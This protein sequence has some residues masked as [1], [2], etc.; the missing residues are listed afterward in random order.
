MSRLQIEPDRPYGV[1]LARLIA[2]ASSLNG[3]MATTGPKI[4]AHD[5]HVGPAG[6]EDGWHQVGADVEWIA[7][8]RLA[9][10]PA[11]ALLLADPV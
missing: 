6:V 1:S 11:R 2:S 4:P 8:G 5:P 3:M 10:R 9:A 7:G